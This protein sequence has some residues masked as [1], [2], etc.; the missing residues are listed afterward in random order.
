MLGEYW[1]GA[2][3]TDWLF[4]SEMATLQQLSITQTLPIVFRCR[5]R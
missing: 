1:L 4:N 2:I 5:F 3:L